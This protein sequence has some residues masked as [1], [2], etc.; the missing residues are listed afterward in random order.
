FLCRLDLGLLDYEEF[1]CF[2]TTWSTRLVLLLRSILVSS[3]STVLSAN[4]I[5]FA[6]LTLSSRLSRPS[7]SAHP[8]GL[9]YRPR[10]CSLW[11]RALG[12]PLIRT[13]LPPS[14]SR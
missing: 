9:S 8:L 10:R 1:L 6:I 14:L 3:F 11:L 4:A 12:E 2:R 7:K 5:S 13:S